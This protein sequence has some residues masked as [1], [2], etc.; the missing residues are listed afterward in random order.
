MGWTIRGS[1]DR[2]GEPAGPWEREEGDGGPGVRG[3]AL[4]SASLEPRLRAGSAG[5]DARLAERRPRERACAC[6]V[7]SQSLSFLLCRRLPAHV[8]ALGERAW[9]RGSR[10]RTSDPGRAG[11]PAPTR[12]PRSPPSQV[13]SAARLRG[14]AAGS[15]GD[16]LAD[17]FSGL[18][19]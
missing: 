9:E 7:A 1:Y 8:A 17:T 10:A 16:F 19:I 15:D 3:G 12:K 13:G 18:S 4:S 5:G 14:V 6:G 11:G 2:D